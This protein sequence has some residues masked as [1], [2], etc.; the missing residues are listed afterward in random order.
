MLEEFGEYFAGLIKRIKGDDW[1]GQ[2]RL[3]PPGYNVASAHFTSE[4]FQFW[5]VWREDMVTLHISSYEPIRDLAHRIFGYSDLAVDS[6]MMDVVVKMLGEAAV[7]LERPVRS[8][9]K[10]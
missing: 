9:S 6:K 7:A 5:V 2:V 8:R 10:L 3:L 1:V 4:C